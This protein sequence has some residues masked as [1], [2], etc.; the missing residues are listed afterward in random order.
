MS[1]GRIYQVTY[2]LNEKIKYLTSQY[3]LQVA[4]MV[5]ILHLLAHA[6]IED[7]LADE[8]DKDE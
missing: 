2:E 1:E 5:G 3:D 4:E 7:N 8:E 6:V